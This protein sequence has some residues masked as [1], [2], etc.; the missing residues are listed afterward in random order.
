MNACLSLPSV[1]SFLSLYPHSFT[2]IEI[3]VSSQRFIT[4][5]S[6]SYTLLVCQYS[7]YIARQNVCG[8]LH[9][10]PFLELIKYLWPW[11]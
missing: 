9:A 7:V 3:S 10:F 5:T 8:T 4:L 1:F 6:Q 2:T 11:P